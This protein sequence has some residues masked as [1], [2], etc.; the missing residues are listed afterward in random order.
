MIRSIAPRLHEGKA[1]DQLEQAARNPILPL[2][3]EDGE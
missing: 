2:R 3:P 1:L